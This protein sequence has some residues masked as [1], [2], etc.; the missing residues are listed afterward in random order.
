MVPKRKATL[1]RIRANKVATMK[2]AF[3]LLLLSPLSRVEA[4]GDQVPDLD[5][6]YEEM[7]HIDEML[8]FDLVVDAAE[9]FENLGIPRYRIREFL[10]SYRLGAM[11][12]LVYAKRTESLISPELDDAC[13]GR[14]DPGLTA[15]TCGYIAGVQVIESKA[16][17]V[18]MESFGYLKKT[19]RGKYSSKEEILTSTG[20]D[21]YV[22]FAIWADD[23]TDPSTIDPYHSHYFEGYLSTDG[24]FGGLGNIRSRE[25]Y[26]T[27]V[28]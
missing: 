8:P 9:R 12:A 23:S 2:W 13:K 11:E 4:E 26:I 15:N 22:V 19:I 7:H 10:V 17:P 1:E 3:L 16:V 14:S 20:A 27:G 24:Y 21:T 6:G 28:K 25:F 5:D 18:S